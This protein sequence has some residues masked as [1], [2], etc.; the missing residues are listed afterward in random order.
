MC[1]LAGF[2]AK[3]GK[4]SETSA[5]E[6]L[7]KMERCIAHRGPDH[8]QHWFESRTGVGFAHRRLAIVD[9]SAEGHQ[10]KFSNCGRYVTVF[11]GEIYNYQELRKDLQSRGYSFVGSSDTE[12]M[13]SLFTEYGV[14]ESIPMLYGMFAIVVYDLKEEKVT[15]IRDRLGKKP[16]YYTLQNQVLIFGSELK[17]LKAFPEFH[18][19][20]DPNSFSLFMQFGVILSPR[21]I[22]KG[23][24]Q[25][26]PA[27]LVEFD[28]KTRTM[29]SEPIQ[30][31][32]MTDIA[33]KG[34]NDPYTGSFEN[35]ILE[36]DSLIS[37]AT[38]IRMQMDVPWGA[39][40]S[41]GIDSSIVVSHMQKQSKKPVRTFTIG[42]REE[43][44]SEAK[45]AAQVAKYLGTDHTELIV[46]HREALDLIPELPL[47]FDEPFS[48]GSQIP[49][50]LVSKLTRK[51]VTVALSGDGGDEFFGG[52]PRHY[53]ANKLETVQNWTPDFL[54][55][56]LKRVSPFVSRALNHDRLERAIGLI[57]TQDTNELY[58]QFWKNWGITD[59]LFTCSTSIALSEIWNVEGYSSPNLADQFMLRDAQH[60]LVDDVLVKV[61]RASMKVALETR[62][63]L[64]DH[65]IIEFAW[66]LPLSYKVKGNHG[67]H[68]LRELLY[69]HVPKKLVD[70]PKMG[71]GVPLAD[72][73]IDPLKYWAEDLLT[74]KKLASS[75]LIQVPRAR[76][77]WTEFKSGKKNRLPA[78]WA[79]LMFQSWFDRQ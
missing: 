77:L 41:G 68:I 12:V 73:L 10:P 65:R 11:N 4:F 23:V 14:R 43:T 18:S 38:R 78:V 7:L 22:Y 46:S 44:F 2:V 21:T 52:Y 1:G 59:E 58:Q 63:P 28:L 67:K 34:F 54:V 31:W 50:Y 61:D 32:S 35:A 17:A 42:Y 51:H 25:L 33:K 3:P 60:Y 24:K 15:L 64:L 6:I 71:F 47:I 39:F 16:L 8:A 79:I 76:M 69:R 57:S 20:I 66:K 49:T 56:G 27:G 70:R 29:I 72:W 37:D 55:D 30:Y 40:L 62:A 45:H 13:L 75:G 19:Q 5:N 26:I 48:D 36:L 74:E 9:L 53:L